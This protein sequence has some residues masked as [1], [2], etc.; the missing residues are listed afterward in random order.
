[1]WWVTEPHEVTAWSALTPRRLAQ[2]S[3]KTAIYEMR[4]P[5]RCTVFSVSSL[6]QNCLFCLC[7]CLFVW[8]CVLLCILEWPR[9]HSN[10]RPSP[11]VYWVLGLQVHATKSCYICSNPP[12]LGQ[13]PQTGRLTSRIFTGP[14][15]EKKK[16]DIFFFRLAP[17][18]GWITT[19]PHINSL[20]FQ[21]LHMQEL[22]KWLC[23]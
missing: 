12:T 9:I 19:L 22:E 16:K 23:Q 10:L 20:L 6:T 1:M 21:K 3:V 11:S 15:S 14:K 7:I 4:E 17:W 2:N 5:E 8:D 18:Q 13:L